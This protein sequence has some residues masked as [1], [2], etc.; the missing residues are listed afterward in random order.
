VELEPA[1]P[2]RSQAASPA[3]L[4][5]SLPDTPAWVETRAM[6]RESVTRIFRSGDRCAVLHPPTGLCG[7]V[8]QPDEGVLTAA[9]AAGAVVVIADPGQALRIQRLFPRC[10]ARPARRI[11]FRDRSVPN[12]AILRHRIQVMGREEVEILPDEVRG[13]YLQAHGTGEV[14]AACL[15]RFPAAFCSINWET[16]SYCDLYVETLAGYR[17]RGCG[18]ACL[19]AMIRRIRARGKTAVGTV[20]DANLRS[21]RMVENMRATVTGRCVF[22]DVE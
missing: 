14:L 5:A 15:G 7:V 11:A 12:P 2:E 18:A 22:I 10:R 8:G 20:E 4:L 16:E 3:A 19:H 1:S 9:M 17:S 13:E 6:L 21:L